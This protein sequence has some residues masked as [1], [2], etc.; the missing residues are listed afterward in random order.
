[1]N[2]AVTGYFGA[3]SSAVLDLLSEYSCNG[4]GIKDERGGYEHNA[5]YFPGGLFDLEDKLLK[6]NDL[7]RSDEAIATF[8]REMLRLNNNNF[9]W[10]GSF[11]EMFGDKFILSV[12]EFIDK[13]HPFSTNSRYYGQC[14]KV[15]FNPLKIPIQIAA[16]IFTG[17]IIYKW[18]R[19]FIYETVKPSMVVAFPTEDEFYAAANQFVSSYLD[20]FKEEG[21]DNTLFDRILLC[22]N[23]YRLPYYFDDDFRIIKV[24]RDVRDI[25]I[26]NKYLWREMNTG[27]MYPYEILE[28]I[29]YWRRIH[30]CE[31]IIDDYR[32]LTINFEDLIYNYESTV[33]KIEQHCQLPTIMHTDKRK[34]FQLEKSIKNTQV[35]KLRSQWKNE[36]A[37]LEKELPLYLY[38]FPYNI[39][40]SVSEMFDNSRMTRKKGVVNRLKCKKRISYKY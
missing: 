11:K 1:M 19:Q 2:I 25:Y 27:S 31:R 8:K 24:N 26:L 15:I 18:G 5:L 34:F 17:R 23:L 22:H 7:H 6:N 40:T 12:D 21:K 30:N 33:R 14:K 4:T 36:I 32:I 9:G 20:M 39:K 37:I 29:D 28:F 16:K 3:G 38:S 35:Y 10:Y 13:L